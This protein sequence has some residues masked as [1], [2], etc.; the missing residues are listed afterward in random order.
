[1]DFRYW[2]NEYYT[3]LYNMYKIM[4]RYNEKIELGNEG[5]FDKFC[6]FVY[7]NDLRYKGY[8]LNEGAYTY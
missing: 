7:K 5:M 6:V 4:N 2:Q 3:H 8:N 1:M